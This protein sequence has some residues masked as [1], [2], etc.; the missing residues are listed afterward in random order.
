MRQ[1]I[2]N[3]RG[4]FHL[5]EVYAGVVPEEDGGDHPFAARIVVCVY[6]VQSWAQFEK[7][8]VVPRGSA[9]EHKST[10]EPLPW[11]IIFCSCRFGFMLI[12]EQMCQ[13]FMPMNTERLPIGSTLSQYGYL[14]RGI[15]R[16]A[17]SCIVECVKNWFPSPDGVYM[18]YRSD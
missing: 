17:P 6:D 11:T 18:G 15:R 8:F 5:A 13:I 2:R 4:S 12:I 7:T 9:L 10:S 3:A 16:V 14:G 1:F